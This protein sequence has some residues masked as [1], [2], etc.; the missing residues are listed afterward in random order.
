MQPM[1]E[2]TAFPLSGRLIS[3]TQLHAWLFGAVPDI[4]E[5]IRFCSA[6][7]RSEAVKPLFDR[8]PAH[9]TGNV[10]VRWRFEDVVK[11]VSDLE[12]YELCR[13]RGLSLY[14]RQQFHGKVYAV[15]PVGIGTGSANATLAGFGLGH[16]N[17]EVCTLVPSTAENLALIDEFFAGA[18]PVD[19]KLIELLRRA[20]A[21]AESAG[22]TG[23]WPEEVLRHMNPEPPPKQLLVDQCLWSDGNWAV[24]SRAPSTEAER[25]DQGLLG[26]EPGAPMIDLQRA[27]A[28]SAPLHWLRS[29]LAQVDSAELYFGD[30]TQRLHL[31][32][33]DDP[34]PRRSEVK[35]LLQNML[36]WIETTKLPG[37]VID[38]PRHSQRVRLA[39]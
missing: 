20:C 35:A 27:L 25:H 4:A 14:M 21:S 11:G 15:S 16:A 28:R 36:S 6:F 34:G 24:V 2:R 7:I 23:D 33:L 38:R 9:A 18:T 10:L 22:P 17:D 3:G 32:L 39:I 37:I 13:D 26:F 19:D 8:L 1:S 30:V 29:S 5:P 12:L 31:A